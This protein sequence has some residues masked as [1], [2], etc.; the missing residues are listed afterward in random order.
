MYYTYRIKDE[1]REMIKCSSCGNNYDDSFKF[2][3]QCGTARP[4]PVAPPPIQT[5]VPVIPP[6]MVYNSSACPKCGLMDNVKKVS[7]IRRAE[8]QHLEGTMPVSRTYSD[9]NGNVHSYTGYRGF[10]ATQSSNLADALCPPPYPE[11]PKK[12]TAGSWWLLAAL[13]VGLIAPVM[14]YPL[15]LFLG[16]DSA[17]IILCIIGFAIWLVFLFKWIGRLKKES[18]NYPERLAEANRR[19]TYHKAAMKNWSEMYYCYRDG[20]VYIPGK[21]TSA[22]VEAMMN[23]IYDPHNY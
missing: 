15:G 18:R 6:P 9:N 2:C 17:S 5:P 23:Y 19:I 3:P 21:N 8:I 20:C 12:H 13:Y 22:P 7:E 4:V 1:G 10:S 14:G 11:V 16:M